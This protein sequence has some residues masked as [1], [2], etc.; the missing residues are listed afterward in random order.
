MKHPALIFCALLASTSAFAG[1]E[2]GSHVGNGGGVWACRDKTPE[3][4]LLSAQLI[5]L[6]E[7][8]REFNLKIDMKSP[9][10]REAQ[11][12]QV[13]AKI[14]LANPSFFTEYQAKMKIVRALFTEVKNSDFTRIEDDYHRTA[15]DTDKYCPGGEI[16]AEQL[17]NFTT[18]NNL[19]INDQ[20]WSSP[21][22]TETDRAALY[23]HEAIYKL[24]RD[25]AGA[26]DSVK[27]R[28]I[29]GYLFS[30][31]PVS[32]YAYL[33]TLPPV[34][35]STEPAPALATPAKIAPA[36]YHT[37]AGDWANA[38]ITY[39]DL[40]KRTLYITERDNKSGKDMNSHVFQCD[41]AMPE[42]TCEMIQST[43]H[44]IGDLKRHHIKFSDSGSFIWLVILKG[45]TVTRATRYRPL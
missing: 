21:V 26:H 34:A 20:I 10:D 31:L 32:Q 13:E 15:P 30:D 33:L 17:A 7:G 45:T 42:T 38:E 2:G 29:V 5:D 39:F 11:I 28:E 37:T 43:N 25:R 24:M 41:S 16:A 19:I 40:A 8:E 18:E 22:L 36:F 14:Q 23:M 12:A 9:L 6:S 44:H 27:T 1:A 4:T 3:H 35:T